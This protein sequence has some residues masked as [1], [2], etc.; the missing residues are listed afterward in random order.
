MVDAVGYGGIAKRLA[1]LP[2]VDARLIVHSAVGAATVSRDTCI[3]QLAELPLPMNPPQASRDRPTRTVVRV[4]GQY[5]ADRDIDGL[6]ALA[7]TQDTDWLYEIYGR[8][9]P[10]IDGWNVD[11]AFLTEDAFD[12]TIRT[13]SVV[14]IP[15]TRFFQSGVAVRSIELGTPVVGPRDSS[16]IE[17][18]GPDS[19]WLVDGDDW[20][21]AINAAIRADAEEIATVA[22]AAY[23]R[24][25]VAWDKWV[26]LRSPVASNALH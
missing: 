17:L 19:A 6:R 21:T 7:S 11:D 18:L 3:H 10:H 25:A 15:Y 23:R 12:Q 20:L 2:A 5:K 22:G 24:V 9:W 8:G 14:I 26:L 16:L 1:G 4:V 13:S